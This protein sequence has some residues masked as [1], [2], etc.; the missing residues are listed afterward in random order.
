MFA[1]YHYRQGGSMAL[2]SL[3]TVGLSLGF[4]LRKCIT[5]I[6]VVVGSAFAAETCRKWKHSERY[7]VV[8][9]PLLVKSWS[10]VFHQCNTILN[11]PLSLVLG[12]RKNPLQH[13][14]LLFSLMLHTHCLSARGFWEMS[15]WWDGEWSSV[16]Y[17]AD[18]S[19]VLLGCRW[20]L[21]GHLI[22]HTI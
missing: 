3:L 20:R 8:I 15:V 4:Q 14:S 17:L 13:C 16:K 12:I 2:P 9:S 7:H 19:G 5:P 11:V 1:C 21:R 10:C 6:A 22:N 18:K